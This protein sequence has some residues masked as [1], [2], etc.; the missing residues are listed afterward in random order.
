MPNSIK[1]RGLNAVNARFTA[2]AVAVVAAA[3]SENFVNS[4]NR[5]YFRFY[6]HRI[7]ALLPLLTYLTIINSH[8]IESQSES[9]RVS[10]FGWVAKLYLYVS[11]VVQ[12]GDDLSFMLLLL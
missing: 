4:L 12:L 7:L 11:S 3:A 6:V 1:I 5:V 9:E 8:H 2:A 10:L